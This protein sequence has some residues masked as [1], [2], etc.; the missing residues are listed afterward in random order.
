[1]RKLG[2]SFIDSECTFE[3][4]FKPGSVV[5]MIASKQSALQVVLGLALMLL[6][7]LVGDT[8]G[9][10]SAGPFWQGW[11]KSQGAG[12]RRKLPTCKAHAPAL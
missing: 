5:L 1:M 12:I 9:L 7:G 4:E 2:V 8:P 11:G 6:E 10:C 3:W